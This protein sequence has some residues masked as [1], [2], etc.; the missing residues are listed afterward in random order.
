MNPNDNYK[1]IN[2]KELIE[3]NLPIIIFE[4]D[5][6]G[7]FGWAIRWHEK[8]NYNHVEIMVS[9]GR[10]ASQDPKGYKEYPI[11]N[12]MQKRV[13]MKF[14][15]FSPIDLTEIDII[16]QQVNKDLNKPW[17]ARR[18]DFLGIVGQA[19]GLR[20][21]QSPWGKFCSES[22]AT[23]LRLIPRLQVIIP[24]RPNPAELNK[25]FKTMSEM[26]LL[27]YWWSD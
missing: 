8:D 4:E 27:G 7:L 3:S 2:P 19:V 10:V 16:R 24:K 9:L 26:K 15:Q 25:I 21:I 5:R 18:Y 20:W 17:W 11:E 1:W 13:F 22:V 12:S 14:W 6:Q 23:N